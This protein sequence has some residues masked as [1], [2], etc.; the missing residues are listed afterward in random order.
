MPAILI[1]VLIIVSITSLVVY[2]NFRRQ[3]KAFVAPPEPVYIEPEPI[4]PEPVP[5]PYDAKKALLELIAG[6]EDLSALVSRLGYSADLHPID[7]S[8]DQ[9]ATSTNGNRIEL[10]RDILTEILTA[11][12]QCIQIISGKVGHTSI[13]LVS[14]RRVLQRNARRYLEAGW[15]HMPSMAVLITVALLDC[16]LAESSGQSIESTGLPIKRLKS[17]RDEI[18]IG[19]FDEVEILRRLRQIEQD[20]CYFSS[21]VYLLLTEGRIAEPISRT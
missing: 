17:I 16:E 10:L 19:G 9:D 7:S 5:E 4:I 15:F 18:S 20:G 6:T 2:N 11:S 14:I 12:D 3:R 1:S 21:I 8:D 13:D